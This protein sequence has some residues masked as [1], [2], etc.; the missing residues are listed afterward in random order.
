[1]AENIGKTAVVHYRGTLDDGSEF[2]SSQGRD[3]LSF[4][5]GSGMVIP[6]FDR[7]VAE[8]A[9]GEKRSV[10]IEPADAYGDRA[11]EAIQD[12]P[13]EA[14]GDQEPGDG[15]MVS[16]M[17]PDGR[18]LAAMIAGIDADT[19]KLDFNHP[20]AGQRL[21][22]EIELLEL[23]E[24]EEVDVIE[25]PDGVMVEE[26]DV[27][28]TADGAMVVDEEDEL[29]ETAEGTVVVEDVDVYEV[30]EAEEEAASPAPPGEKKDEPSA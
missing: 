9:P 1:M 30:E 20:L 11:D 10:T 6:G 21:T 27:V 15:D 29:I 5:I 2:D 14:F 28:E 13:R 25:T 24:T 8:M 12:V 26:I 16:L 22:F 17:A 4:V 7:T 23:V 18:Q 19:I 3:P